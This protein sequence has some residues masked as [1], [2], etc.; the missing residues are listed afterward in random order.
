MNRHPDVLSLQ[1]FGS[2]GKHVAF[3]EI[4]DSVPI[5]IAVMVL[6]LTFQPRLVA[7]ASIATGPRYTYHTRASH[8]AD[9]CKHME[10]V[11]NERFSALWD[12]PFLDQRPWSRGRWFVRVSE[13]AGWRARLR[14]D[15]CQVLRSKQLAVGPILS[16][17]DLQN[18]SNLSL[19]YQ[20]RAHYSAG[21]FIL[22]NNAA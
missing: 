14:N 11:F 19:P 1:T 2:N 4:I 10:G 18:P 22:R 20:T 21:R 13:A 15:L 6:V 5:Q 8:D 16:F 17:W 7:A 12:E 9:L 3:P